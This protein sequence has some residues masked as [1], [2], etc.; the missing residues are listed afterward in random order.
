VFDI[1]KPERVILP[2]VVLTGARKRLT[3]NDTRH[4]SSL[5]NGNLFRFN[6]SK[7]TTAT[8]NINLLKVAGFEVLTAVVMKRRILS[9]GK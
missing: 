5:E 9:S 2:R 8:T 1:G 4:L 3:V 6:A 7:I